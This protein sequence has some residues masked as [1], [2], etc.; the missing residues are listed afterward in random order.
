MYQATATGVEKMHASKNQKTVWSLILA[1]GEGMRLNTVTRR[2]D[3]AHVPKQYYSFQGRQTLLE[4]TCTRQ[5][6]V[7]DPQHIVAVVAAHHREFWRD[8]RAGLPARNLVVQP[9]DRGTAMGLLIGLMHIVQRQPDA[10][11]VVTP[12]DHGIRDE[13]GWRK[14]LRQLAESAAETGHVTLL[15]VEPQQGGG[16]LGWIVPNICDEET[17]EGVAHFVEKPGTA[18]AEVLSQTDALWSTFVLA[19]SARALLG[20]YATTQP[21]LLHR[22]LTQFYRPDGWFPE[23]VAHLYMS[24]P[25]VDFSAGVLARAPARLRVLRSPAHGWSDLGTPERLLH[26]LGAHPVVRPVTERSARERIAAE[27]TEPLQLDWATF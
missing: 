16:D 27:I 17:L 11:V 6:A 15:G 19:G 2:A 9:R 18:G 12:A 20:L 24:L 22:A 4:Q 26:F 21:W 1:A 5:L 25:N 14:S 7:S 23:Q 13:A 10:I 8:S 3:G